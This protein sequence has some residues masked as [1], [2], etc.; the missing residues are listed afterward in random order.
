[1]AAPAVVGYSSAFDA[2][3]FSG[4]PSA[5]E[6][7]PG[8]FSIA[9][10][11]H[12]YLLDLSHA[13]VETIQ[14]WFR[15]ESLPLLRDQADQGSEPGEQSISPQ[16]MWRRSQESWH[17]GAGQVFFDREDSERARFRSS[18]GVNIWTKWQLSLLEQTALKDSFS[19]G[20]GSQVAVVNSTGTPRAYASSGGNNLRT[21]PDPLTTWS[22]VTGIPGTNCT[23]LTTDGTNVYSAWGTNRVYITD[24][25]ATPTVAAAYVTSGNPVTN[26]AYLKGRLVAS[27]LNHLYELVA[28]GA[29]PG[30]F[31]DHPNA[32]WLWTGF[33]EGST[34]IYAAGFAG[35][36]STVYKVTV[37]KD[38]ALGK[39]TAALANGLPLGEVIQSIHGSTG[40][41]F[42][43]TNRGVR[44]CVPTDNGDLQVGALIETGHPVRDFASWDRFVWFTWESFDSTSSG[45]GRL[46]PSVILDALVP[47]YAS[48]IMATVTGVVNSVAIIPGSA[49]QAHPVFTIDGSG[50]WRNVPDTWVASGELRTGQISY[51]IADAK[52]AAF[53]D[54]RHEPLPSGASVVTSLIP[55]DG[56]ALAIGTSDQPGSVSPPALSG[57][58][59]R[60]ELFELIFT[61]KSDPGN[62]VRP[63]LR[64]WTF[65]VIPAPIR[66]SSWI[67]PLIFRENLLA[68]GDIAYPF[69]PEDELIFLRDLH[70][71]QK[72]V[73]FQWGKSAF[74]VVVSN[75][76]YLP[77]RN[78]NAE[79]F[80]QF[81]WTG[82]L[83][84][85][86]VEISG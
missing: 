11:G 46:D 9:V 17:K 30:P 56:A 52:V 36:Y 28:S 38:T 31:F 51:G 40:F 57:Q 22:A 82:T 29:L 83:H 15:E 65:R 47:A 78:T 19:G 73:N 67:L 72:V 32:A 76:L 8:V 13:S 80:P 26:V 23:S 33:A 12:P 45:L 1:M 6:L 3:F 21:S 77:D 50:V 43:G 20:S 58:Q 71:T 75:L 7:V 25:V 16:Q 54:L 34:F 5:T 53:L 64:R 44:F 63:V 37:D 14:G 41:V 48:D 10:D 84:L 39:P 18:K 70:R 74:Q 27:H 59:R 62:T 86:L 69:Y 79:S 49:G 4:S 85:T 68:V 42:L 81:N 2:P 55:D 61:L 35:S 66:T 60:A 24:S